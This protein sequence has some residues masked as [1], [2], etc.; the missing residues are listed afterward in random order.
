MCTTN[1]EIEAREVLIDAKDH[2]TS[3]VYDHFM[4][5]IWLILSFLVPSYTSRFPQT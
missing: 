4:K 2:I 3:E 5:Y 1:E